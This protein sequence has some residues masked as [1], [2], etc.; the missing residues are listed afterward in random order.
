M[1][2]VAGEASLQ[3]GPGER[4][5][6]GAIAG[7]QV[8]LQKTLR[9]LPRPLFVPGKDVLLIEDEDVEMSAR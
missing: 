2:A 4:V 5:H 6:C 9:G 7:P 3:A 8:R 1:A